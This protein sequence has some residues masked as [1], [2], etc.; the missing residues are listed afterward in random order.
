MKYKALRN[1]KV[2]RNLVDFAMRS[3]LNI[4]ARKAPSSRYNIVNCSK[5]GACMRKVGEVCRIS[6]FDKFGGAKL[7]FVCNMWGCLR[8][9]GKGLCLHPGRLAQ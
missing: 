6:L 4:I 8:G 5:H 2:R 9:T 7:I 1:R 3:S